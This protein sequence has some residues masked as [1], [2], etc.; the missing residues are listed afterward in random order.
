MT[1]P[2]DDRLPQED[3]FSASPEPTSPWPDVR[4]FP[5]NVPGANV[6][7][8]VLED[9]RQSES[10]LIVTGYASLDRVVSFLAG[11]ED[12]PGPVRLLFGAE[13]YVSGRERFELRADDFPEE[14]RAYWLA[15]G[16]SPRLSGK[17]LRAVAL[18]EAGRVEAR[19]LGGPRRRLH[20]KIYCGDAGVTLGSSNFTESGLFSQIEA[21]VRFTPREPNRF[22]EARGLAEA[23]WAMGRNYRDALL[24]LL[25]GLLRVVSW[26]E[27]L[28]RACGELIEGDWARAY[29][30]RFDLGEAPL[31]PSQVQGVAQALWLLEN[32]GSVLVADATG[33]GKTRMGAHLIRAAVDRIWSGGRMR[34][35]LPVMVC[36]PAVRQ[37]WE[38]EARL[39]DLPLMT[40]S[41]G[42]L[43]RSAGPGEDGLGDLLR[44]AQVLAVDEAHNFLNLASMRTRMVLANMA[45]HTLLF[46]ATPINRSVIDLLRI[47]DTL[48]ADNLAPE[49]LHMFEGLLR[50]RSLNRGLTQGELD[51]LRKEVA[52]FTVRRTKRDLN[53]LVDQDPDAYRDAA[54]RH[55]RYPEHRSHVYRLMEPDRDRR[56]AA[57]IRSLAARLRGVLYLRGTIE[58]PA[59]LRRERWD[60]ARY[61]ESRLLA[62]QKLPA[63]VVS[64]ALRSS[65]AALLEHLMGTE[66]ALEALGLSG[67][68]TKSPVG[69]VI[70]RLGGIGGQVPENRLGIPLPE[71]LSDAEAHALACT[72]EA[73]LYE[74]MG[75][76][77][78][79]MSDAR[80]AAKASLLARLLEQHDLVLAFDSRPITLAVIR[81]ALRARGLDDVYLATGDARSD[82]QEI[83]DSLRPGSRQRGVVALCSDSMSEGVN[84]QQA[85]TIVHL[86]MPSVVRIAEQRVGRVDRMDSPHAHIDAWWP[87]DAPEFALHTDERFIE[88][89]ETVDNLLGSN[90]PL[91][92][93]LLARGAQ[94]VRTPDLVRELEAAAVA[95]PWD[96]IRDAF[97]PVRALVG[98]TGALVPAAVYA[99]VSRLGGK[100]LARVSLVRSSRPWAFFCLSGH[101]DMAPKWVLFESPT[102]RAHGE[103]ERI[104]AFLR[105]SLSGGAE[106]AAMDPGAQRLLEAFLARLPRAERDILPRRKRR[107][108][109]Q[110]QSVLQAYARQ[111]RR[112]AMPRMARVCEGLLATLSATGV[113]HLPDWDAMAERWL[114]LVRPVWYRR[115]GERARSRPLL[116]KDIEEHLLG[117]DRLSAARLEAAFADLPQASSIEAR[118][119]ACILGA[120]PD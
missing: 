72:E 12:R 101:A 79:G 106:D 24:E 80:E 82:R 22:R 53:H 25:N 1:Q 30:A 107:A 26:Q 103:L 109:E 55:C 28:A 3:L 66:H 68:F 39:C 97:E 8:V 18:I 93:A 56:L 32:V 46:T 76:R 88:R 75:Q 99:E 96:G 23:L 118:L 11:L 29:L 21:N 33:S 70:A 73:R 36:P 43:S 78:D 48:G 65:R 119:A 113:E 44:R 49:T 38:R 14:V 89:F 52:R 110:M 112:E 37:A 42:V 5:C 71:W 104:C 61:L 16:I 19:F 40:L 116:L 27:A 9:L 81:E 100:V 111:A 13:P 2:P 87:D 83:R 77:L 58:M 10:P 94:P 84:L 7:D 64:A 114:D 41:H 117:E 4:R 86:D 74:A 34:K 45:D 105:R 115:L 50:R 15:R 98:G 95:E 57:E 120:P 62:A 60:P 102:A 69:N 63:Y 31:W 54:G 47:A 67:R 51:A 35:G 91:P 90:L 6:A 17:V 108:L 20:A 92:E 59:V 85:S